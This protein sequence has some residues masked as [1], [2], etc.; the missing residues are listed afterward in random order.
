MP[1]YWRTASVVAAILVIATAGPAAARKHAAPATTGVVSA[2]TLYSG[3]DTTISGDTFRAQSPDKTYSLRDQT[4][5]DGV[6]V[7]RFELRAGDQWDNDAAH[8][9]DG[10]QRVALRDLTWEPTDA[11]LWWAF[12]LRW[13]GAMPTGR[14]EFTEL[15]S[16]LED[17]ETGGKAGPLSLTAQSGYVR[18]LTRSDPA[19]C[20]VDGPAPAVT[21][22]S[23]PLWPADTWQR[24]V[25]HVHLD[26]YG[27]GA[28]QMWWNGVEQLDTAGIPLGFNDVRGPYLKY[29]IYRSGSDLTEVVSF[30]NVQVGPDLSGR[31]TDPPPLPV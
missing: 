26:P 17:C 15:H 8:F 12:D 31:V 2:T 3:D 10:R 11:D 4:W 27:A 30:A 20:S 9:G 22:W 16:E 5:A 14:N 13:S 23:T 24:F 18:L 1:R 19:A 28:V 29:G 25:I 6:R 7:Q 21:R